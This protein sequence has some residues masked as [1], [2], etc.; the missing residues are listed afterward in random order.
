MAT[1]TLQIKKWVQR[2]N[3]VISGSLS[4]GRKSGT[5]VGENS[6]AE[7]NS[8]EA[9]G[10]ASRAA[11]NGTVAN[12]KAQNVFGEYNVA[13]TS[14]ALAT[15]R[16][17]YAEIVGNGTGTSDRSNARTL[18]W[19]GNERLNGDLYV[20]CNSDGTGGTKVAKEQAMTGA[21]TSTNG[22]MG[23]VPAPQSA[24][25]AKFLRGDGTWGAAALPNDMSGATSQSA[26]THGLV[27]APSAGDQ[28]KL[29]MGNG[30]WATVVG[31][32]N[33]SGTDNGKVPMVTGGAWGTQMINA[34]SRQYWSSA[35]SM[36]ISMTTG[37]NYIAWTAGTSSG[38]TG[39]MMDS[40][41]G[42]LVFISNGVYAILHKGTGITITES[43]G[44]LTITSGTNIAMGLIEL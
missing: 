40:A 17:T 32:P 36:S 11:G 42:C 41:K 23:L 31:L 12:H 20:G 14:S 38:T 34:F 21:T 24:D 30:T 10:Y 9:S 29:L 19:N 2:A 15:N 13:D 6:V 3:A 27:P 37:K 33:V 39:A 18:D 16:G 26:G 4:M 22:T 7:G 44:T 43:S 35:T 8:V 5:T 1:F 25:R 28:G